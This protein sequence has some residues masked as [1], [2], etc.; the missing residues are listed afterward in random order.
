MKG[1]PDHYWR[2][3]KE[4]GYPARSVWKL[5]EMQERFTLVRPGN[6]VLDLG[7]SPGSW[8]L[9]VLEILAGRG[10]VLGVD[11]AE[12][13]PKLSPRAGF[14]F[15]RGNFTSAE[16]RA[17]IAALGPFDV[18][19]SDAAPSTSGNRIRD[20]ARS[21]EI[22]A[23]VLAIADECL[24]P[25]GN[26]A[27]KLFPGGEEGELLGAMRRRFSEARVVKPKA[28]RSDSMEIYLLGLRRLQQST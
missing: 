26:L 15:L 19:L 2:M 24:R 20:T 5:A 18:V 3:S 11:L 21:Q 28:S 9:G 14:A 10:S 23:A 16:I 13:D 1:R 12:P 8:S 4:R 27:L 6:R 7:C 25:G 17:Q 22:G